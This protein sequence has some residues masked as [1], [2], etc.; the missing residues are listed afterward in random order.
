M[1]KLAKAPG[2]VRKA[3]RLFITH[4]DVM[5]MFECCRTSAYKIIE[6]VNRYAVTKGHRPMLA[7]KA[8]KYLFAEL[9]GI[10][11]EE[12]ERVINAE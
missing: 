1:R 4:K 8:S 3:P 7:G 12:V 10:P 6:E 9:Y 2:V 5:E 11:L